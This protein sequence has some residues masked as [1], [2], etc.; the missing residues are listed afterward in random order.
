MRESLRGS[1]VVLAL[2]TLLTGVV[3][4][5]VVTVVAQLVFPNQANGSLVMR[6]GKPIGSVLIGQPFSGSRYFWGRPSATAPS[7]YNAAASG[8]SNLGPLNPDLARNVRSLIANLRRFDPEIE[9]V[10]V[11]L[12]TTSGSGLDPHLSPAAAELQ[13]RR[14]A[15]SRGRPETEVRELIRQ[16][17]EGRQLGVLGEPRVNVFRLNLALDE[18][19]AVPAQPAE[20]RTESPRKPQRP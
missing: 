9:K 13:V 4:P 8:G 6:N 15:T 20:I 16:Q 10:P 19:L 1:V 2:M 17:T 11:D 12:V 7:P 14:V 3:Y 5:A 18:S